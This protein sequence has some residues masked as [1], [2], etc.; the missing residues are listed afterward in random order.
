MPVN[1]KELDLHELS[2]IFLKFAP[3]DHAYLEKVSAMPGQGV[4][5]MFKF[6]RN[7]GALQAM[8]AA[9]KIPY[10]EVTPQAWQKVMHEGASRTSMPD[11]KDRSL[12]IAK[13]LF[14]NLN[15]LATKLSR[16]PHHGFVDALLIAEYGRRRVN[17]TKQVLL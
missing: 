5:S 9:H 16:K 2:Q 15:L 1:G 11:P 10:T 4:S 13:K 8:L 14:P 17:L 3:I 12:A 7:V 6:G